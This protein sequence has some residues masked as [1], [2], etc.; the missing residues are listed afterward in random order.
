[1]MHAAAANTF[2]PYHLLDVLAEQATDK[3]RKLERLYHQTQAHAWDPRVVLDELVTQHGEINLPD[4]TREAMGHVFTVLLWGE[5]AAWNIATDLARVLPDVAAKMAA[6]GQAFD[7]ARHFRVLRDYLERAKVVLPP[8]NPYGRRVLAR[9]LETDSPLQKLYG[10]QLLVENLA[11]AVFKQ[12]RESKV[13]PVLTALLEYIERDEARHVA[14]GV[15]YLPTLLRRSTPLERVKNWAFNVELF[16]LTVA[17][18]VL[19]D[20]HFK[21]MKVDHR[22]L[23]ITVAR[24]HQHMVR[25]MAQES[26]VAPRELRGVYGL[27]PDQHNAM[28]DFLHPAK[29]REDLS[30]MHRRALGTLEAGLRAGATWVH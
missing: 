30:P 1:M 8:V 10:M 26:G 2:P 14:L 13:E 21:V 6:T 24:L 9:V 18:G 22:E 16:L 29:P 3:A 28:I 19:L 20:Q 5:L 11:L 7:E 23:G 25:Q 12:L 15:M 4:E 27:T 17:G